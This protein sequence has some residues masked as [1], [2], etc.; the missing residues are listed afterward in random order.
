MRRVEGGRVSTGLVI[1]GAYADKLRRTLFAQLSQRIKAGEIASE[2]VARASRELNSFLYHILVDRLKVAKDDV[3]RIRADYTIDEGAVR[4]NYRSIE[5]EIYRKSREDVK[6]V[7]DEALKHLEEVVDRKITLREAGRT[8]LGDMVYELMIGD[9]VVGALQATKIDDELLV[10]GA[11]F[12][13]DPI[14]LEGAR[15]KI[16]GRDP[17]E[18]LTER[19]EGLL[20]KGRKVGRDEAE[21]TIS[22]LIGMVGRKA[23]TQNM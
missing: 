13:P 21:K 7:I 6:K 12:T 19:V 2:E 8:S 16:D 1:A 11:A 22:M 20:E 3:V 5:L 10:R 9:A 4:W 17:V 15:V 18:V 23:E 14:L